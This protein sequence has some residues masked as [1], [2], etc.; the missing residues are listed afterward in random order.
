VVH[1]PHW[2]IEHSKHAVTVSEG[3][4]RLSVLSGVPPLSLSHMLLVSME[5]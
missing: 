1:R 4:S 3:T 2:F 5:G